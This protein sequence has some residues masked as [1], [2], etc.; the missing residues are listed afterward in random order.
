[1]IAENI[2]SQMLRCTGHKLFFYS[3]SDNL[4]RENNIKVDFVITEG[5]KV[6]PIEVKS[7]SNRFHSSIDKFYNKFSTKIETKY[8]LYTKD[9]MIKDNIVYLPLYMTMFL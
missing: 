7:G 5:K 2:V 4:H 3:R 1:M 8:I 6:C 9:V